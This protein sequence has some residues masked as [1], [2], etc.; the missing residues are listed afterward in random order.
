MRELQ[1]IVKR[2]YYVSEA[3]I[4]DESHLPEGMRISRHDGGAALPQHGMKSLRDREREDIVQALQ[5]CGGNAVSAAN[6]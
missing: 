3:E 5:A 6:F 4:I 1:N 2:A